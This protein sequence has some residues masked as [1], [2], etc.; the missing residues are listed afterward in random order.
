[1][2][3]KNIVVEPKASSILPMISAARNGQTNQEPLGPQRKILMG[4]IDS[5]NNAAPATSNEQSQRENSA[6]RKNRQTMKKNISTRIN[7]A[8]INYQISQSQ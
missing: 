5:V 3:E 4:A 6:S 2:L 7:T 1:M 8:Y